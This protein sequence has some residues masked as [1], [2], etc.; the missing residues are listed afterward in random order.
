MS[1]YLFVHFREKPTPDGEQ[2]YFGLSRDG[3]HWHAVKGGRPVLWS[4]L[5]EKGVR[6]ATVF[7][8]DDGTYYIIATDLSLAYSMKYKYH[9]SWHEVAHRGSQC[10]SLWASDDLVH[11]QPQ[12]LLD[13]SG[14]GF[15]S[16]WAPDVIKPGASG[17]YILHWS[18]PIP[19]NPSKKAIYYALTED[20]VSFSKPE[21]LYEKEDASVID[22]AMYEEDG[23]F[24]LFV[25]SEARPETIIML[26]SASPTGPFERVSRFD[27]EM[28]KLDQGQYEAP[29]AFKLPDGR[30]CLLLDYYGVPGKG[31]GY[32][33][34]VAQTLDSGAFIRSE[35]DFSFPY[36]FKHGTVLKISEEVCRAIEGLADD[37]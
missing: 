9:N 26:K 14:H 29:T 18:S 20:F 6:D 25:K 10:L 12:R 8:H 11:F 33:P 19:G 36:G 27:E 3:F 1:A 7:R 23:A 5:G 21:I 22:S 34:F 2:V 16:L 28:R 24:Y 15:G 37:E 35:Q 17:A 32:V 4:Y 31:Q 13:F 30:W